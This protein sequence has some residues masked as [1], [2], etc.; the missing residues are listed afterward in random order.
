MEDE[1]N[2]LIELGIHS[3]PSALDEAIDRSQ[4]LHDNDIRDWYLGKIIRAL[5]QI[6]SQPK[7]I[8][9]ADQIQDLLERKD[10]LL[11]IADSLIITA[12]RQTA[13]SVLAEAEKTISAIISDKEY[14][15]W[16]KAEALERMA[17]LMSKI[18]R[19]DKAI[20]LRRQAIEV[21]ILGQKTMNNPQ[22]QVDCAGVLAE[23]A[24]NLAH[25]GDFVLARSVANEIRIQKRHN[26]TLNT[27]AAIEKSE[28]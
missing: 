28:S 2:Q 1:I 22:E 20:T 10:V 21:A 12:Q 3:Q 6:G 7:A 17:L 13:E 24:L 19:E 25:S 4:G 16:Q 23:I 11:A 26:E 27:I 18:E 9:L 15:L 5:L 14:P 8:D